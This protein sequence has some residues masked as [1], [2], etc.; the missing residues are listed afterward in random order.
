M[1]TNPSG[2]KKIPAHKPNNMS[3][4][5]IKG[6]IIRVSDPKTAGTGTV[7]EVVLLKKYHDP[8]TGELKNEDYYPCQI[9]QDKFPDFEKCYHV[10]SKMEI[11]GFINGRK[12]PKDGGDNFFLNFVGKSFKTL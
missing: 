4:I 10:N 1:N 8:Q 11:T 3:K 6:E 5:T 7:R 12:I 9:W 2:R